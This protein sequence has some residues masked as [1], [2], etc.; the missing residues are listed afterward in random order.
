MI[1]V[2]LYIMVAFLLAA[3]GKNNVD[4][5]REWMTTS[6]QGLRGQIDPLPEV[7]VYKPMAYNAYDLLDPFNPQKLLNARKK[8]AAN[9]P[10]FNR[11]REFLEN[12]DLD[13]LTM[14]GTLKQGN[15]TYAL[16]RTPSSIVYRVQAGNF[17]G[18]NFGQI[19]HISETEI[20]I[21]EAVED[22]NGDWVP[23]ITSL[24]LEEQGQKK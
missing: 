14:V 15:V 19:K 9:A 12:F 24:T 23:R 20:E 13:K 21:S 7:K 11:P 22:P 10:D 6:S 17:M 2:L 18:S 3:C 8:F 5:L 1:K 16:V 4:D